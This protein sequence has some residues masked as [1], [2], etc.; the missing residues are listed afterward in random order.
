MGKTF[1]IC[2][3]CGSL[4]VTAK[5][6]A[7]VCNECSFSIS[8]GDYHALFDFGRDA[9]LFGVY[10]RQRYEDQ[11]QEH[12]EIT[13]KYC[14]AEPP[15]VLS[16]IGGVMAGGIIGNA[17]YDLVKSALTRLADALGRRKLAKQRSLNRRTFATI[18]DLALIRKLLNDEEEFRRLAEA[19][20]EYLNGMPNVDQAVR[21]AII[22]EQGISKSVAAIVEIARG[23][24]ES[25]RDDSR[26]FVYVSANGRK[27]H[28]NGCHCL[29]DVHRRISLEKAKR[30]FTPC[31][32][33]C[34]K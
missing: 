30:E 17:S 5:K 9:I 16:F 7:L 20:A 32:V 12:G 22:D 8:D 1:T 4:K 14:L 25:P 11:I 34:Q 33:C 2:W 26:R 24:D 18:D 23:I 10:Y 28:V 6:V 3:R 31:K 15:V 13:R 29:P 21:G 27:Y 19:I